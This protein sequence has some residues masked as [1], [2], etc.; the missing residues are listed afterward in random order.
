MA[1]RRSTPKPR[2]A[3]RS[4]G[5]GS[6]LSK[7]RLE[8]LVDEATIDAHDDSEQVTGLLTMLEEQLDLPFETRVLGVPVTVVGIDLDE[9]DRVVALCRRGRERQ[10]IGLLDLPL[11]SPR[12]EGWEWIE[13][14]RYWAR[15]TR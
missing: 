6:P 1:Q 7:D 8:K 12:P 15:L 13:A 3:S 11:P 4:R 10:A 9:S 14:Y 5:R 2:A